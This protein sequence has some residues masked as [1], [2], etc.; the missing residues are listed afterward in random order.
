MST[1]DNKIN[2]LAKLLNEDVENNTVNED[3]ND[4]YT[5]IKVDFIPKLEKSTFPR[6]TRILA[7]IES[8][9][10]WIESLINVNDI[11]GNSLIGV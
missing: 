7:N 8:Y 1:A 3:F 2:L 9:L 11:V 10:E 5:T 6:K 4:I